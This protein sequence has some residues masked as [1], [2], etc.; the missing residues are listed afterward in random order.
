MLGWQNPYRSEEI[1][2]KKN[3][4]VA[5]PARKRS[6]H[7]LPYSAPLTDSPATLTRPFREHQVDEEEG[8]T[9]GSESDANSHTTDE[10]VPA[11]SE[12]VDEENPLGDIEEV[13]H[14]NISNDQEESGQIASALDNL[15][16]DRTG[17]IGA[18]GDIDMTSP[19]PEGS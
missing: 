17:V 13:E 1:L 11:E 10:Y 7:Y 9:D 5:P 15:G 12:K 16:F 2:Q 8:E 18:S 14:D 6:T 19:P 3:I 4:S